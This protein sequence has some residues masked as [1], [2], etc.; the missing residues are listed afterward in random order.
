[1]NDTTTVD[2]RVEA[3]SFTGARKPFPGSRTTGEGQQAT[4]QP[5]GEVALSN[6]YADLDRIFNWQYEWRHALEAVRRAS[7][8]TNDDLFAL[9]HALDNALELKRTCPPTATTSDIANS[10]YLGGHFEQLQFQLQLVENHW[11]QLPQ[12]GVVVLEETLKPLLNRQAQA[13]LEALYC[14][15][16]HLAFLTICK[17]IDDAKTCETI[18]LADEFQVL[19][20]GKPKNEQVDAHLIARWIARE[21]PSYNGTQL[22]CKVDPAKARA[23]RLPRRFRSQLGTVTAPLWGAVGAL[24][25]LAG[26][27]AML[28]QA[29]AFAWPTEP[30]HAQF[31]T[32][33]ICV[34]LG[35]ALHIGSRHLSNISFENALA[36]YGT[37]NWRDWISLHWV[38]IL[39]L[40]IPVIFVTGTLWI[41]SGAPTSI[42]DVSLAILS[43]YSADSLFKSA[44][45]RL[46]SQSDALVAEASPEKVVSAAAPVQ[47][48]PIVP[49]VVG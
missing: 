10:D 16:D 15:R 1:M 26:F 5:L 8:K 30:W 14:A 27:L 33:Y 34:I 21:R 3:D 11:P 49:P 23:Y 39:Q 48:A 12:Q 41:T 7:E 38:A 13:A 22:S 44:M 47:S 18:A 17:R 32:L 2:A 45:A 6:L 20:A 40:F 9:Q 24:A 46:G 35:A 29:K 42:E 4:L 19:N 25:L 28:N 37:T 31:V 36:I 43:G